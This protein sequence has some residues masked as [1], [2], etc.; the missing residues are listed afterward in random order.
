M[1][2]PVSEVLIF[3]LNL[4]FYTSLEVWHTPDYMSCEYEYGKRIE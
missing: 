3:Q 2:M 4:Q 1:V